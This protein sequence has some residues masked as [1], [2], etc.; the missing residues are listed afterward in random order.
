LR[1]FEQA[2][3]TTEG[4]SHT[5]GVNAE[6]TEEKRRGKM[7]GPKR[8]KRRNT[9]DSNGLRVLGCGVRVSSG[10]IEPTRPDTEPTRG[11]IE[12]TQGDKTGHE[13]DTKHQETT[14]AAAARN[15][16]AARDAFLRKTV[17]RLVPRGLCFHRV[18]V[19]ASCQPFRRM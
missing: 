19:R 17:A 5:F 16:V 12:A 10:D 9:F 3:F 15:L 4:P 14:A 7:T 13:T 11:D 1:A 2:V 6:D 18:G 8:K